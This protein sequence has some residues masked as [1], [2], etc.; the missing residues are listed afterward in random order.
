MRRILAIIQKDLISTTRDAMLLYVLLAPL[1]IGVGVRIFLPSV[2]GSTINLTITEASA[3]AL[4]D[5]LS[6]FAKVQ[7]VPHRD[8]LERRVNAYDEAVG[9]LPAEDGYML[10]L[11]GNE[12]H[13]SR[14]LAALALQA[15]AGDGFS[16]QGEVVEV[17]TQRVPYRAWIGAF[18]A[19]STLFFGS[20]IMGFHIIEDK[21]SGMIEAMGASPLNRRTYL[22]ARAMFMFVL[23][24]LIVLIALM[25]MGI[26]GFNVLQVIALVAASTTMAVLFGFLVGAANANQ[27]AGIA[28]I[29][30]GF[31][32]L[33][34][35]AVLS[36]FIPD[37]WQWTLYW[38]PTYW[39]FIGFKR[40]LVDGLGWA[41][42][43]GPLLWT[44]VLSI[45]I[46]AVAYP[47]FKGKLSFAQG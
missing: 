26:T 4:E 43:W 40:L 10:V 32:P 8:A 17:D 42:L 18:T 2:G 36:L 15:A 6:Q 13:E 24:Q 14:A 5:T 1:I 16:P 3:S 22:L 30:I 27:I 41:S 21:E 11:E 23:L 39:S 34:M 37:G 46:S 19:L 33:L 38:A 35:P 20:M 12:T 44:V 31:W 29:K 45:V 25:A 9:I 28:F 47:W 7:V